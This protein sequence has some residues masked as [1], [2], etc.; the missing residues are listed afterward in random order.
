[1]ARAWRLFRRLR[2][3]LSCPDGQS[4]GRSNRVRVL[5]G[6]R[7]FSVV[8]QQRAFAREVY[9]KGVERDATS[10][11]ALSGVVHASTGVGFRDAGLC[12]KQRLQSV[13]S[14]RAGRHV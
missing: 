3:I 5:F 4:G 2:L 13:L 12:E 7:G 14:A 8:S 11:F 10:W 9:S 1:M 6:S